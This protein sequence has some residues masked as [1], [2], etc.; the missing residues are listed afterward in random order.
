MDDSPVY[1]A[2][3][4][5]EAGI[6]VNLLDTHGIASV[7]V[8]AL[9]W[10]GRGEL[11]ANSYPRIHLRRASDRPRATALIREYQAD[12]PPDSDWICKACGERSSPRFSHCW[13]CGKA[14]PA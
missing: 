14:G 10:G 5:I 12:D 13:H 6:V 11:P 7:V 1:E 8:G 3:D 9:Q 2:A 4:P